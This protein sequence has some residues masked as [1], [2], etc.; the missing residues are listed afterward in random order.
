MKRLSKEYILLGLLLVITL[1]ISGCIPNGPLD[2]GKLGEIMG[3]ITYDCNPVSE[4]NVSIDDQELTD[5]ETNDMGQYKFSNVPEGSYTLNFTKEAVGGIPEIDKQRIVTVSGGKTVTADLSLS[6]ETDVADAKGFA[7]S[8][9]DNGIELKE[10]GQTQIEKIDDNLRT[11][12][13]PY[14]VAVA[15]RMGYVGYMI[16]IWN[17]DL[18]VNK[19]T[20]EVMP[21]EYTITF[22]DD[23][24]NVETKNLYDGA[25]DTWTWDITI[26]FVGDETYSE[27]VTIEV[28]NLENIIDE[29][30]D[31]DADIIYDISEAYFSYDHTNSEGNRD[32]SYVFDLDSETTD[33]VL[34]ENTESKKIKYILPRKTTTFV[35]NGSMSG[36]E[37]KFDEQINYICESIFRD[38]EFNK[39]L[40]FEEINL[41]GEWN[42][43]LT[44]NNYFSFD[45]SISSDYISLDGNYEM[46]FSD[47]PSY[48]DIYDGKDFPII[49]SYSSSKTI[50]TTNTFILEG[51]T[52]IEFSQQEVVL[53]E[54]TTK[55]YS[56][57]DNLTFE[58]SYEDLT[59]NEGFKASGMLNVDPDY[60]NFEIDLTA[61]SME[62]DN[63]YLS[64]IINF[65]GSLVNMVEAED[66]NLDLDFARTY[67]EAEVDFRYDYD[68]SRYIE[69]NLILVIDDESYRL[70]ASNEAG[71]L[72]VFD[73]D[74]LGEPEFDIDDYDEYIGYITNQDG[75]E[76]F[77]DIVKAD[78]STPMV[79][80]EDGEIISLI[81]QNK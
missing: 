38:D 8:V 61:D 73:P 23:E 18:I 77:A 62:D 32:W 56:L 36:K 35:E 59:K 46:N 13:V 74:N 25:E 65:E 2:D 51:S 5:T 43:D 79:I 39:D 72:I 15:V 19:K 75:S 64:L 37:E 21:G 6:S 44:D 63:N 53:R 68:G 27:N 47:F 52:D 45:G 57:P 70:E 31:K 78:G 58:G 42:L 54:D 81:P 3:T 1:L 50:I 9:R 60:S 66:V 41:D 11:E 80:F 30:G 20:G 17:N 33:E 22:D 49:N 34:V 4:V 12:I 69:G 40:T 16:N 76:Y 10:A 28:T 24:Y 29:E 55:I 48:Q 14:S 26:Y 67:N 71:L 7:S